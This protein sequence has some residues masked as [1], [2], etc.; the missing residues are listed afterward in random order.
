MRNLLLAEYILQCIFYHSH[1]NGGLLFLWL[2][3]HIIQSYF[4]SLEI[5]WCV[6]R[7]NHPKVPCKKGVLKISQN[8][9]ENASQGPFFN[10]AAGLR[11]IILL[12]KGLW[13]RC[14]LWILRNFLITPFSIEY[15][16][17]LLLC[18]NIFRTHL[19][20]YDETFCKNN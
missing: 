14:F 4:F 2:I 19:N 5:Y 3:S 10:K 18:Y 17:W 8:L 15:F 6:V 13:H 11:P 7:S 16:R 9:Q 12:K 1:K 20:I